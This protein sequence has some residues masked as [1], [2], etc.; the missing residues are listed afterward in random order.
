MT[1]LVNL[2]K[3][4]RANIA[5]RL[6]IKRRDLTGTYEGSW[7]Q[8][9]NYGNKQ[10]VIDWGSAFTAIDSSPQI[11]G[12]FEVSGID[13]V[14]DNSEGLF[15]VETYPFSIWYPES[16]YLN[17]RYTKIKLET[18]YIDDDGTEVGTATDFEGYIESV[19]LR[20]DY[21]ATIHC[22]SYQA[23]LQRYTIDDLSLTGSKTVN[24]VVTAIMNQAK[25]TTYLP[26][27]APSAEYNFTITDS[28]T[29]E[30]TY[31]NILTELAF[32][33]NS[34]IY[35]QNDDFY[36]KE[37]DAGSVVWNF[38]GTNSNEPQDI[39][40]VNSYDDEGAGR[41]RVYFK[42][43][44]LALTAET[45]DTTLAL[46][47]KSDPEIV[48][49]TFA[50]SGDRQDILDSLL[51]EFENPKARINFDCKFLLNQIKPLDKITIEIRGQQQPGPEAGGFIWD[52]WS[53]DD[54]S[55]WGRE[56][57]GII[58]TSGEEW[59]VLDVHKNFDDYYMTISAEKVV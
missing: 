55:V 30:G 56:L 37:R 53:W 51:A 31:W 32:K 8:V 28:S 4:N 12:S 9:D 20:E 16:D 44:G 11:I 7:V 2:I 33:S 35:L 3:R 34:I 39:Y 57:G 27:N 38:K 6:Y 14:V 25:I 26:Y 1:T 50:D 15:N 41:V 22:L 36:F 13:I 18:G 40:M 43:E 10:R 42:A 5:R 29:L 21:T 58:I 45:A 46:K 24:E 52:A 54:G 23:I 47:Y 59:K 17:R 19:E 49:I 48:D